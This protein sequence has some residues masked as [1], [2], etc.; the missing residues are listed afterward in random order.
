MERLNPPD[1]LDRLVWLL[2]PPCARESVVGDLRESCA[3]PRDYAREALCA[4]PYVI[5]SQMRRNLNPPALLLQMVLICVGLGTGAGLAALPL[6]LLRDAYQPA[7]RPSHRH[8]LRNAML[9]SF[10]GLVLLVVLPAAEGSCWTTSGHGIGF[11]LGYFLMAGPLSLLLCSVRTVL[12]LDGDRRSARLGENLSVAELSALWRGYR[13]RARGRNRM[14]ALLLGLAALM[15][16]RLLPQGLGGL[17]LAAVFAGTA[18]YLLMSDADGDRAG[19]FIS[20]RAGFQR[21]LAHQ[22]QLRDFLWWLWLAPVLMTLQAELAKGAVPATI[23]RDS[24][25]AV[26]LCFLA[27]ALNREGGGQTREQIHSLAR[28]GERAA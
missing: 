18:L 4:A 7:A 8:A 22:Q 24:I 16:P 2:M 21:M 28:L 20:L 26:L 19:D 5:A 12:I 27:T 10:C 6:L 3:S 14:E 1:W 9:V 13:G 11:G 15:L 23:M 17:A 25:V